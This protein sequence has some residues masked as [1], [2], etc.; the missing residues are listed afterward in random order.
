M[1]IQAFLSLDTQGM[2]YNWKNFN[3]LKVQHIWRLTVIIG[4]SDSLTLS[5]HL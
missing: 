3:W 4:Y 2:L 1:A 5:I